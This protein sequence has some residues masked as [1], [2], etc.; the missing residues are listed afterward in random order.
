MKRIVSSIDELEACPKRRITAVFG[1]LGL[2]ALVI[3]V[4]GLV[5]A[6]IFPA[7]QMLFSAGL[8]AAFVSAVFEGVYCAGVTFLSLWIISVGVDRLDALV[9]L[10]AARKDRIAI[11]RQR[12]RREPSAEW[13][14]DPE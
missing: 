2:G 8:G 11:Y 6:F 9:W 1:W 4:T 14:T 10:N 12:R 5:A 13:L 3:C 7:S